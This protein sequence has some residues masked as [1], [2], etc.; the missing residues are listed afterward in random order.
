MKSFLAAVAFLTRVPVP[1]PFGREEVGRAAGWFPL[2]G[3]LLGAVNAALAALLN[4]RLPSSVVAFLLVAA[5]LL[6]TGA[7]H[8]DGLADTADGFGGGHTREDVL[9]IMRDHAIG[10]Y[11]GAALVLAIGLQA[12]AY[13]A[14]LAGR[15]AAVALVLAPC[16][17]RWTI[18]P[19]SFFLPYARE[20]AGVAQA[21]GRQSFLLGTVWAAALVLAPRSSRAG[22][23]AAAAVAV[24]LLFGTYCRRRIGGVTGD[25]LGANVQISEIAVL[26]AFLWSG[27]SHA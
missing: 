20:S 6:L 8:C 23:G 19:Q 24:T 10:S 22:W 1:L 3:G 27:G 13:Q 11:G 26:L 15:S 5:E 17:G 2:V 9:R 7:L 16:L 4:G 18:L 12:A 14:L 25:T 21:I